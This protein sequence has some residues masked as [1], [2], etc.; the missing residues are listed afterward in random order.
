MRGWIGNLLVSLGVVCVL[1]GL[2]ELAGHA[3]VRPA[4][5]A[6]GRLLGRELPPFRVVPPCDK[7]PAPADPSAWSGIVVDGRKITEGDLHGIFREDATLGY[8]PKENTVSANGWWRSDSFGAREVS[9]PSA[10]RQHV[11]IFGE[12]FGAGSR[13][14]Q[15]QVWSAVMARA[16]PDTDVLN[17]AVDGYSMA[18]AYLRFRQVRTE[19][20]HDVAIMVFVPKVDPPRDINVL[21][22]VLSRDWQLFT[23]MPR[24]VVENG[25]LVLAGRPKETEAQFIAA[26]CRAVS[27]GL[28]AHLLRYDRFYVDAEYREGP[29]VLGW[30]LLYKLGVRAYANVRI[31]RFTR[32]MMR[33]GSEAFD[34]TKAIFWQMDDDQLQDGGK[35]VL[36]FLPLESELPRLAGDTDYR[37]RWRAAVDAMCGKKLACIDL[38]RYLPE[39]PASDIDRG[40][41]GTHYGPVTNRLIGEFIARELVQRHVV[42]GSGTAGETRQ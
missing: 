38:A 6:Y 40:Y 5:L 1:L 21:R 27:A 36:V 30:S 14:R 31:G 4:P 37:R 25:R 11:V 23:V 16:L 3:L 22:P 2:I 39:L 18:Q 7:P 28:R 42:G 33:P 35:F 12:S 32:D 41:D 17:F 9:A 26:N 13:I 15:E 34:V 29:A 20:R 10:A 19:V 8:A 24:F